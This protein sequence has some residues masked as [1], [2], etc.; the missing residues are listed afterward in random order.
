LIR[1]LR[2]FAAFQRGNHAEAV[3]E[4]EQAARVHE[5]IEHRRPP[6]HLGLAGLLSLGY[7]KTGRAVE[8]RQCLDILL[9]DSKS[10]TGDVPPPKS[11]LTLGALGRLRAG[12]I[13]QAVDFYSSLSAIQGEIHW[14]LVDRVLGLL[15]LARNDLQAALFHLTSA[16]ATAREEGLRPELA[17]TLLAR[18]ELE[19]ARGGRGSAV[20]VHRLCKDAEALFTE[21][22]M[23]GATDEAG[24]KLTELGAMDQPY[25]LSAR[26]AH[27][28]RLVA[29]GNSNRQTAVL[30]LSEKTVA[31]HLSN[32]FN[33][34][35]VPNRAAATGF[36]IREG[37]A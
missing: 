1:Q 9:V 18:A 12:D 13:G 15:D 26:E 20:R 16:E 3:R 11:A 21:L 5:G 19:L 22:A 10:W 2:G 36:A 30:S 17:F 35:G 14:V 37:I 28:L 6:T 31:N 25:G 23:A 34:I 8:A 4:W 32:I 33:K 29:T 24:T 7:L 27:V